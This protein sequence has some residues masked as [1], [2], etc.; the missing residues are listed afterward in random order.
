LIV[1]DQVVALYERNRQRGFAVWCA[2]D[3][4]FVCPSHETYPF[5]WFWDF[6]FH[7]IVL[8]HFDL[9]RAKSEITSLLANQAEDGFVAHVT[10]WQREKYEALLS[11]YS[12]AYRTPYLSDCMQPPL[13]AEAVESIFRASADRNFLEQ[14]LPRVRAYYDW[15]DRVRDPDRDGLIAVLQAD[16]TGLDMAPKFD[17]Y[18]GISSGFQ[19]DDFSAGWDRVAQPYESVDRDP[20]RMFEL[21]VFVVEDVMV[22]TIYA[23]NQSVLADLL[24]EVGISGDE[25]RTRAEKTRRALF[26]KCWDEEAGLFFDLAGLRE[27]PLETNSFTSLF[28]LLL[29]ELDASRASRLIA[30]LEDPSLYGARY[31]VPTV[32][33]SSKDFDPGREG[34][35]LVWRGP[36][37]M[38][39]NW[40]L[41]RGS[42]THGR[43]DLAQR[44]AT[45]SREM[46][47][48]SGFREYYDPLTGT[49][50]G[51]RDF[52][53]TGLVLDMIEPRA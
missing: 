35:K 8:S 47:E 16:E 49:G 33:L 1:R 14:V 5:Q 11:T 3:Y 52:S 23:H 2:Q 26:E 18:L 41:A 36:A 44:I 20:K 27:E 21:D 30:Q 38:N 25:L 7:A 4:D 10:F 31:P 28:P 39:S 40:Y 51:A 53:W 29:P 34:S 19:L 50:F 42:R 37:W 13:L 43:E 24:E 15:C 17:A 12:I 32:P 45:R 48:R 22:N 9:D 6:C 46:V